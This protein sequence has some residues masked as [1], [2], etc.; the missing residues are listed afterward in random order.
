M[1]VD[2]IALIK[3][4]NSL[5]PNTKRAY[6]NTVQ[7]WLDFAGVTPADWTVANAQA[8]YD[9]LLVDGIAVGTANNM[10]TG[11]LAYAL[12][13]AAALHP[14]V[15]VDVTVAVDRMKDLERAARKPRALTAL[16]ANTLRR[17][18]T[19]AALSQLRDAALVDIELFTG[20]R[21]VSLISVD[22]SK[23][24]D[25][26]SHVLINVLLKGGAH[27]DVP[28][29]RRAWDLTKVYRTAL[30]AARHA[31]G[32]MFPRI[33][34]RLAAGGA[35]EVPD[36]AGLTENGAYRVLCLRADQAKLTAFHPHLFRH[37]FST[38][39]RVA[40]I[41]PELIEVV[42][43]HK[44]NRGLVHRVYTDEQQLN[45]DVA[46]RCYEAVAAQLIAPVAQR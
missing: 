17:S 40:K 13:R 33:R 18:C 28:L 11:G 29:D 42:T 5:Q 31:H 14:G 35:V 30:Y 38:W 4:A 15:V 7:Q 46:R 27:E 36:K 45:E 10:I 37:T 12:R 2:L 6:V 39:C 20:M 44:S 43:R 22:T 9:K 25:R 24:V 26:G 21:L 32:P 41:E 23:V 1:T 19:G 16:Q 34:S 8:F 3:R